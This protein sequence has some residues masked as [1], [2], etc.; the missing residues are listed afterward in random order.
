MDAWTEILD[1]GGCVDVIYM[2][3]QKAFDTVPHRRLISKVDAHGIRGHTLQWIGNFLSH[4]QQRV[5]VNGVRSEPVGVTSGVPQGSVLGPVLFLMY[6]NDLPMGISSSIKLFADDTKLFA[7]PTISGGNQL[8]EDLNTLQSW[9]EDWLLSF[10]PEKSKV[11]KLG[12]HK[13]DRQYYMD[14]SDDLGTRRVTL[15]ETE[16][17]KDL[18]VYIDNELSFKNHVAQI[19]AKANRIVGI[20]R[21]SFD[22]LSEE[23]FVQLYKSLV[24][25]ILEYGHSVW[26]PYLKTLCQEVEKVQRRATKLLGCLKNLSYPERLRRLKLPSL[27]HRRNRGDMIDAY[28]YVHGLYDCSKP[29]LNFSEVTRT[30]GHSLKLIKSRCT[31]RVRSNFFT[32]RVVRLWNS[33]PQETVTAPSLN[34]FKAR[35]DKFWERLPDLY[36]P[37]CYH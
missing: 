31:R 32:E 4:R 33:L 9:S 25:P 35:L 24:R 15:K 19:T 12:Y 2:D 30:R 22:N 3:F 8:Q 13:S 14:I 21:R 23:L 34:S 27:E 17:E 11:M 28:K 20:I 6:I 26:N 18:G 7:Q 16:V 37:S 1:G 10:H 36:D 29:N 5:V